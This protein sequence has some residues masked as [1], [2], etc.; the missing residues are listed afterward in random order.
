MRVVHGAHSII[1]RLV[2]STRYDSG[3][4]QILKTLY[5]TPKPMKPKPNTQH[6]NCC[7]SAVL[8]GVIKIMQES[9]MR[10]LHGD[11]DG[12][13]HDVLLEDD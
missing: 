3:A 13:P 4:Y 1:S 5:L 11:C 7:A 10:A 2:V 12:P 8:A 6:R 9:S